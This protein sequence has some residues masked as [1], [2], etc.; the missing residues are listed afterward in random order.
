M[1]DKIIIC[2]NCKN[3][4]VYSELEQNLDKK[5]NR[6]EALYC[7]ICTSIKASASKRPGKPQKTN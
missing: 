5:N 4:F 6:P 2:D 3:P 7:P 1:P